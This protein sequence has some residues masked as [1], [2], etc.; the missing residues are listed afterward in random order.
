LTHRS[1]M[2]VTV[3][4]SAKIHIKAVELYHLII[5][6]KSQTALKTLEE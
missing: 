2:P 5:H 3:M 6:L 1:Y 4:V